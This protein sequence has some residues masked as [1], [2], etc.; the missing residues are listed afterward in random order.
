MTYDE[1]LTHFQVKKRY[2]DKSQCECP[3]HDDKQASLT[4]TRGRDSVL[5]HCHAGCDIDNVL[6]A[7]GLKKSDLFYQE[8]RTGSSWRAYV[9]SRSK[10]KIEAIYNY[11]SL[12]GS[13]AF[14]KVRMQGKKMIYGTLTNDR[15]SY[16]LQGQSRKEL[17]AIYAPDGIEAINKAVSEGKPIFIPEGE[18]DA[19]TLAKQGYTAFSYGGVNDWTADM[20]QLCKGAVVYVLADND[21]PGRRVANTIQS[22]LQGIAESAKIIVPVPDILKADISDYFATGH[23]RAEFESLLQQ[24]GAVTEKSYGHIANGIGN[25]D[26]VTSVVFVGG[27]EIPYLYSFE[28]FGGFANGGMDLL[29]LFNLD[30]LPVKVKGFSGA[31]C[32]SLQVSSGM[33]GPA[34]LAIAATGAQKKYS[35]HPLEDW[36]EPGN[37]YITIIA[38]PSERKSPTMKEILFPVYEYEAEENEETAPKIVAYNMKKKSLKTG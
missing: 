15:F 2:P 10:G 13:Y 6:A 24:D 35:I 7:A 18:K 5:I 12:N 33:V 26:F 37:L 29:P 8:K 32:E 23:T 25:N 17:K 1:I 4:V 16:G 34:V 19:D 20:A 3:A 30:T 9:E 28:G 11:V 14:T 36:Y 38:E 22:D 31:L 21:E 27:N